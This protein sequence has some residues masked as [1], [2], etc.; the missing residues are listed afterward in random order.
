MS[1]RTRSSEA[2]LRIQFGLPSLFPALSPLPGVFLQSLSIIAEL[3]LQFGHLSAVTFVRGKSLGCGP[4]LRPWNSV[5]KLHTVRD[6][7]IPLHREMDTRISNSMGRK[8][9]DTASDI[10]TAS[11]RSLLRSVST[12]WE[13]LPLCRN[14]VDRASDRSS[15]EEADLRFSPAVRGVTERA[16]LIY[17]YRRH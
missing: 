3:R 17:A 5:P 7:L 10:R 1:E 9:H 8:Q 6:G 14:R 2:S 12:A 11:T 15:C 16:L 13:I 4:I